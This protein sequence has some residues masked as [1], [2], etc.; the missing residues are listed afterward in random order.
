MSRLMRFVSALVL[1]LV[2]A[3]P[4]LTGCGGTQ[5][6][7]PGAGPPGGAPPP[8]EVLVSLP[9]ARDVT[10]YEDFPGRTDAVNSIEIR[11]R[12]TGYLDHAH[13]KEGTDVKQGD[14]L[15]EI[16]PRPYHAELDRAAANVM[17]AEARLKRVSADH[18]RALE[19]LPRK[20]ISQEEFDKTAGDYAE[21][22][23]AVEVAKAT[24][25]LATLNLGFTKVR[26]PMNGRITRRFID[27]GNLVK[28]DDTSLAVLVSLDPMH[29]Y[30]DLDERTT[31]HLQQLIRAG[32]IGPASEAGFIV[33]MGLANEQ[34]FPRRGTVNYADPRVDAET[35]T[36]RLRGV[37]ENPSHVLSPGLFVRVRV[38]LGT[39]TRATLVSEQALGTDQGQRFVYVVDEAG[40]VA[41]RR[42]KV[43]R[44][45]DGLRVIAEGLEPGEK[46]VVSGLQRVRPGIK[47][48][49]KLVEMPLVAVRDL[50][51]NDTSPAANGKHDSRK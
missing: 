13:F 18:K 30:F 24:R 1:A 36:W 21:A 47:V 51:P 32:K 10:D 33:L 35:G 26:A 34:G 48:N 45:H 44:V 46:V 8:P 41:Y 7:Q 11:A 31:L 6:Q 39:P 38:P 12:V 3:L 49:P 17:Q 19:L 40:A 2:L 23:A 28:A 37:F 50:A 15:F 25:E 22:A 5:A 20:V 4:T 14:P 42:V 27:P 16:D 29:A 43:G 9:L